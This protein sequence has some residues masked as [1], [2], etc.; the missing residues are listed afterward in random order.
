M[1]VN[2]VKVVLEIPH[3]ALVILAEAYCYE[4]EF[5]WSYILVNFGY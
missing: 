5:F 1:P 3:I 4:I 2:V